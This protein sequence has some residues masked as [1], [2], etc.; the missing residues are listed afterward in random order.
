MELKEI[1]CEYVDW[2]Y[3]AQDRALWLAVVNLIM[4]VLVLRRKWN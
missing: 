2:T 1:G 3:I 4:I